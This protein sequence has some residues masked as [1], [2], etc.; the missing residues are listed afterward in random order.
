M[1]IDSLNLINFRNFAHKNL[2]FDPSLTVIIGPNGS[3]KSNILE[4]I[5][6]LSGIRPQRVETDLD[7]I[8]FA[9]NAFQML[10]FV[11]KG[12]LS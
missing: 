11:V 10:I 2:V 1:Y 8:K 7:L 4:A 5:S 9:K 12:F 3:G 6:L